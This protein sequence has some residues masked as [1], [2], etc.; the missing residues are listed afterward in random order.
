MILVIEIIIR[1]QC[2]Q[3]ISVGVQTALTAIFPTIMS[4]SLWKEWNLGSWLWWIDQMSPAILFPFPPQ[5]RAY[6]ATQRV[7]VCSRLSIQVP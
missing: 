2:T 7:P 1:V 5:R 3:P 4:C 6:L